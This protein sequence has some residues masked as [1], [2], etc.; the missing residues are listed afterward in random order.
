VLARPVRGRHT[1]QEKSGAVPPEDPARDGPPEPSEAGRCNR[2]VPP[3][4]MS[5]R[6]GNRSARGRFGDGEE[7]SCFWKNLWG[8]SRLSTLKAIRREK[9]SFEL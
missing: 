7:D 3:E 4:D 2:S 5:A 6:V 8:G 1:P 9:Q